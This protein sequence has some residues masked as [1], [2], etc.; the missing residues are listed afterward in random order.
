MTRVGVVCGYDLNGDLP[1]YVAGVAREL[2]LV[3]CDVVIF[4]GGQTSPVTWHS[5]AWT[6]ADGVHALLPELEIILEERAMTTLDNL[7]FAHAIAQKGFPGAALD[8]VVFCDSAHARKVRILSRMILGLR[9]TVVALQR[10][11]SLGI[12]LFEPLS[13]VFEMLGAVSPRMRRAV[14]A[15]AVLLKGLTAEQRRSVLRA[16]AS[17][18]GLPHRRRR[19]SGKASRPASHPPAP[20]P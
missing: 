18:V 12:R 11:V 13:I 17:A 20:T 7:V 5:E 10:D 4:S 15:G 8:Y 19:T 9:T 16:A 2:A 14:R 3:H 1:A 6:I